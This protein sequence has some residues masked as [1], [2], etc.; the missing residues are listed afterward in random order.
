MRTPGTT[1]DR[2]RAKRAG[3]T[4]IE[5]LAVILIIGILATILITQLGGAEDAANVQTTKQKLGTLEV[6][7]DAY[8]RDK[9]DY[10]SSTFTADQGVANDGLN[11]GIEALVV[12][13]WSNGYEAGGHLGDEVDRLQNVDGDFSGT[14][15]TDF[16][17]RGLFEIADAWGNPLA[18]FHHRDYEVKDRPYLTHHP[19]TGAEIQSAPRAFFNAA[20]GRYYAHDS[21][22][23]ISAGEDAIFGTPDD[24]TKFDRE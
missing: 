1:I 15:L 3:F 2:R 23:L 24:I 13:L 4:L 11:V 16:G 6:V 17:T 12:A 10:P 9:G 22:Q 8:D 18:Y 5:L 21:F 7:L 19:D 14:S 20:T